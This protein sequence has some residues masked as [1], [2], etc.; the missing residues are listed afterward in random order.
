MKYF[1]LFRVPLLMVALIGSAFGLTAGALARTDKHT[2]KV[3]GPTVERVMAANPNVAVSVCL[4]SG[5]I[6]VHG[7]DRNEVRVRSSD[8]DAIEFRRSAGEREADPAKEIT[9]LLSD[10]PHRSGPCSADAD[11]ELDVPRGAIVRLQT[12]DGNIQVIDV[13]TVSATAQAGDLDLGGVKRSVEA[14]TIGGNISLK[15]ST[16]STR[17]YSV[18]GSIEVRGVGPAAAR[19]SFEAATVGGDITLEK[20]GFVQLKARTVD[21]ALSLTGPL[22]VGGRYELMTISG[23]ISLALP[24]DSSFRVDA[25]LSRGGELVTEFP[26]KMSTEANSPSSQSSRRSGPPAKGDL[27]I[28]PDVLTRGSGHG[29]QRINGVYGT[30][31]ALIT[32]SSFSGTIHL[33]KE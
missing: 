13:S 30:G 27:T 21:G 6:K 29:L 20:V 3:S 22:A 5:D 10:M 12:R 32:A 15:N 1:R 2:K 31:D 33:R 7:W 19:D 4:V 11:I 23:D 28:D 26:L 9:V 25:T 16:G 24:A 8:A 18:G 14:H 17:L